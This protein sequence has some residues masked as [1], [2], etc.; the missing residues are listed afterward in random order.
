V[1]KGL[2]EE[3]SREKEEMGSGRGVRREVRGGRVG[4]G[5][6]RIEWIHLEIG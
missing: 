2:K 5:R 1:R 3:M 4:V 6:W